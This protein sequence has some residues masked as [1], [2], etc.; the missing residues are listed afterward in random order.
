MKLKKIHKQ[1]LKI[2]EKNPLTLDEISENLDIPKKKTFKALRKL[3]Q[4]DFLECKN[5]KYCLSKE[6]ETE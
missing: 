2:L 6:S 5:R 3:F 4:N 1:I